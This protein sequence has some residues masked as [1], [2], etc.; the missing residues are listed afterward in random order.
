MQANGSS[1]KLSSQGESTPELQRR[2][3]LQNTALQTQ[4]CQRCGSNISTTIVDAPVAA[5]RS[6]ELPTE[7]EAADLQRSCVA[8]EKDI[9]A[10]DAAIAQAQAMVDGLR[11]QRRFLRK[12]WGRKRALLS[13]IRRLP[14]EILAQI[15]SLAV[16]R[17]FRRHRDSTII[18]RHP[19]LQVCQRWRN[20][21]I[22]MPEL[23]TDFV[24][25]THC[26]Y[27]GWADDINNCLSRSQ[28][29]PLDLEFCYGHSPWHVY[30]PPHVKQR[31]SWSC[32]T[33]QKRR[34][35]GYDLVQTLLDAAPRW[36]SLCI[37]DTF[38]PDSFFLAKPHLP[39]LQSFVLNY[40]AKRLVDVVTHAPLPLLSDAPKLTRITLHV[41]AS[42][43][44]QLRLPWVRLTQLELKLWSCVPSQTTVLDVLNQCKALT[45]L[46]FAVSSFQSSHHQGPLV[47]LPHL[48]SLQLT[49]MGF[50]LLHVLKAPRLRKINHCGR[51]QRNTAYASA[52]ECFQD[53]A[54][55]VAFATLNSAVD[56]PLES[57]SLVI[58]YWGSG[59]SDYGDLWIEGLRSYPGIRYL[60]VSDS[61]Y[62][63]A[64]EAL[65]ALLVA[66][67]CTPDL[68]PH[69]ERLS[70]LTFTVGNQ[71]NYGDEVE[72]EFASEEL[73]EFIASRCAVLKELEVKDVESDGFKFD[74]GERYSV[75]LHTRKFRLSHA[76][77]EDAESSDEEYDRGVKGEWDEV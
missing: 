22:Q 66:L 48:Q 21:A 71:Q 4:L 35:N 75:D 36:R 29:L 74:W 45:V 41:P 70:L 53:A 76:N 64:P 43:F 58:S 5:V 77:E 17:T 28:D 12:N 73:M 51:T 23:W 16:M 30:F 40:N 34:K 67:T 50:L 72:S 33:M 62:F 6:Y 8:D 26:T 10:F 7:R 27:G 60:C 55:L 20:F 38:L 11:K 57:L 37:S 32:D 61:Q 69:L 46:H 39:L 49:D 56:V 63:R 42:F 25:Y 24:A 3:F 47:E 54:L 9:A 14:T 19:V 31:S 52:G 44:T 2:E 59:E 15:I 18:I 13:P 68:L 65:R 1:E